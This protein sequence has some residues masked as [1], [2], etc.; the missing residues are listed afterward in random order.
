ME[1]EGDILINNINGEI[2]DLLDKDKEYIVENGSTSVLIE[3]HKFI[4]L[5]V[6]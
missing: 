1:K 2:W 5:K 6:L 4:I 3:A